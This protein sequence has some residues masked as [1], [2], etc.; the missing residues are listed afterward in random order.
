MNHWDCQNFPGKDSQTVT[1]QNLHGSKKRC[2][3]PWPQS[4]RVRTPKCGGKHGDRA[5]ERGGIY[6]TNCK[7]SGHFDLSRDRD[8]GATVK[9]FHIPDKTVGR[10]A[11]DNPISERSP[12]WFFP[13]GLHYRLGKRLRAVGYL[14]ERWVL[15]TIEAFA[16]D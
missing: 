9:R 6:R 16:T 8:F 13:A 2:G 12:I 4:L 5:F 10:K 3:G 11:M 7:L 14:P 15:L 1:R